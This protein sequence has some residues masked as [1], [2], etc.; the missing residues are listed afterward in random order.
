[1]GNNYSEVLAFEIINK[2]RKELDEI[3]GLTSVNEIRQRIHKLITVIDDETLNNKSVVMEKIYCKVK[4]TNG[5]N[6]RLNEHR[7]VTILSCWTILE[8]KQCTF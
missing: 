1:M 6:E 5:V 4:E 7:G 3:Y 8:E 2:I